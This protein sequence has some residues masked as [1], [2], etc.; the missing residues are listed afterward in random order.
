MKVETAQ[1]YHEALSACFLFKGLREQNIRDLL[2]TA[3]EP[4]HFS[5][6][7]A[8]YEPHMFKR[9]LT[10]VLSGELLVTSSNSEG[11]SAILNTLGCGAVCGV[12]ALFGDEETFV[13]QVTAR[14]DTDVLLISQEVLSAWFAQYPVLAENYIRFLTDRIRFLNRKIT[15][16]TGGQ[17]DDRLLRYLQDHCDADGCV[18]LSGRVSD[19]ARILDVGRSSLYRS[20]EALEKEGKLRR[21][22]KRLWILSC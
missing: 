10:L 18:Q 8:L 14:K 9:V 6:G 17:S 4:L 5:R 12:T 3:E 1:K 7:Q 20:L 19:L 16:Y 15:T 11:K 2:I 13:T 21:D 22:G